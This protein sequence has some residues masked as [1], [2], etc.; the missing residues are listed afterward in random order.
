[1]MKKYLFYFLLVPSLFLN[2]N[3][4]EILS[5]YSNICSPGPIRISGEIQKGDSI[6]LSNIITKRKT[7]YQE[8]GC[9]KRSFLNYDLRTNFFLN[10]TG[11]DV[12]ESIKIGY[13][14]RQNESSV[15]VSRNAQ[16]FSSC[17]FILA[18]GVFRGTDGMVG[19][20]RPYF[21]DLK[22]N[23]STSE[24]KQIRD[25]SIRSMKNYFNEMDVSEAL[26]DAMLS[27]EPSKIKILTHSE[28]EFF[29]LQG[30][31]ANYDEKITAQSAQKYNLSSSEYRK[32]ETISDAKCKKSEDS[33]DHIC[34]YMILLDITSQEYESRAARLYNCFGKEADQKKMES[35]VFKTIVLNQ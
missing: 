24:I 8:L 26:V 13:I 23:L 28:L 19:I 10:T 1:M 22:G 17:V 33:R 5:A 25:V 15:F 20:H 6:K 3:A 31:D 18:G 12:D 2:T 30:T 14:I 11:G 4:A 16:C 29:R 32:R 21:Q 34:H 27:I 9:N 7:Q 35:C